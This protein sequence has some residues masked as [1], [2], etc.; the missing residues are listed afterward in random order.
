MNVFTYCSNNFDMVS[1]ALQNSFSSTFQDQMN[2]FP[3][4]ICSRKI[5][6]KRYLYN[7]I[8]CVTKITITQVFVA[9]K[10]FLCIF[11]NFCTLILL[12]SL[13]SPDCG[14]HVLSFKRRAWALCPPHYPGYT[15]DTVHSKNSN[16]P[17][18]TIF[19]HQ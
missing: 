8:K 1:T 13:T 11:V 3:W 17:F 14:N 7:Y 12:H 16:L 19:H 18:K 4:L 15:T 5:P 6:I 9:M 10:K 2:C